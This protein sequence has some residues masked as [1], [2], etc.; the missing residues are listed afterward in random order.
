MHAFGRVR[1]VQ[2]S[3]K[4]SKLFCDDR[5]NSEL[6]LTAHVARKNV[7]HGWC[8]WSTSQPCCGWWPQRA[9]HEAVQTRGSSA[10]RHDRHFPRSTESPLRKRSAAHDQY[11]GI[12]AYSKVVTGEVGGCVHVHRYHDEEHQSLAFRRCFLYALPCTASPCP[13]VFE[14]GCPKLRKSPHES[15]YQGQNCICHA[16]IYRSVGAPA[17]T[18]V[19]ANRSR[20]VSERVR[21]CHST[22]C[23]ATCSHHAPLMMAPLTGAA[24]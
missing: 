10:M 23:L 14:V 20:D 2:N 6:G 21:A 18:A 16:C 15:L 4:F 24:C 19:V 11:H 3:I 7:Q 22:T 9:G 8:A 12:N 1:R 17:C 5:N 13:H